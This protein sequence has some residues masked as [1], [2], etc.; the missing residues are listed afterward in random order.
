MHILFNYYQSYF[1]RGA[2]GCWLFMH[3]A[4]IRTDVAQTWTRQITTIQIQLRNIKKKVTPKNYRQRAAV[5]ARGEIQ[6]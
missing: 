2:F 6:P 4:Q 1:V 5:P 3:H